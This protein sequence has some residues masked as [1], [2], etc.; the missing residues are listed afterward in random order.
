MTRFRTLL[1]EAAPHGLPL[2]VAL[3]G[4]VV[5]L[6]G[7]GLWVAAPVG[8]GF[9][10]GVAVAV[11]TSPLAAAAFLVA[12]L[13]ARKDAAR[14]LLFGSASLLL[15]LS[16][17]LVGMDRATAGGGWGGVLGGACWGLAPAVLVAFLAAP[18]AIRLWTRPRDDV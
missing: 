15:L 1:G 9:P 4:L 17:V 8:V 10:E 2:V 11:F 16:G 13:Q 12:G 7:V 18:A 5:F 3:A 14:L 6:L